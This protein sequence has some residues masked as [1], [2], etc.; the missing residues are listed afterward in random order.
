MLLCGSGIEAVNLI[1]LTLIISIFAEG[2]MILVDML[3]LVLIGGSARYAILDMIF[4]LVGAGLAIGLI[5]LF[6]QKPKKYK[7]SKKIQR[8]LGDNYIASE[9]VKINKN[10]INQNNKR[11]EKVSEVPINCYIYK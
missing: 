9:K 7:I 10:I 1:I 4:V 8:I 6:A 2:P 11:Y 5:S 3:F